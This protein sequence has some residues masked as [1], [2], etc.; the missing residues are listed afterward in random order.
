MEKFCIASGKNKA[1]IRFKW[2]Q[3]YDIF[4]IIIVT[5]MSDEFSGLSPGQTNVF[6]R[7]G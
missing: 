4:Q 3:N 5:F 1:R 2:Q 6:D 7:N